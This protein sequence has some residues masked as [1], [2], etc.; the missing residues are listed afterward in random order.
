MASHVR[1]A[2][3]RPIEVLF[4]HQDL[5]QCDRALGFDRRRS[6]SGGRQARDAVRVGVQT[7]VYDNAIRVDNVQHALTAID[8]ILRVL[9]AEDNSS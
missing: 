1:G 7:S 4:V 9:Y 2:V 8:K 5:A 6:P 3:L